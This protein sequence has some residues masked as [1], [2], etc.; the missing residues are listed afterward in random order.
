MSQGMTERIA[1][2]DEVAALPR[3]VCAFM[4]AEASSDLCLGLTWFELLRRHSPAEGYAPRIYV[5]RAAEGEAIDCV[6]FAQRPVTSSAFGA[7]RLLSLTNFYTMSFAPVLR[8][9]LAD[10]REP[11]RCLAAHILSERPGWDVLDFR[12]LIADAASTR[13]LE[14]ALGSVGMVLDSYAQFDNWYLPCAGVSG[15]QYMASRPSQLRNTVTRKAKKL[16]KAHRFEIAICCTPQ[17]LAKALPDYQA[18]YA[19][20]WKEPESYPDFVPALMEHAA[21]EGRLRLGLLYV[22]GMPAAAQIWLLTGKKALIYKLAYDEAYAAF[23]VGS[24]LTKAMFEHVL[25]LDKVDEIDYGVG[26]EPYKLDWMSE[27][28]RVIGLLAFNPRRLKG[29][30]AA[31]RHFAGRLWRGW[32]T[33]WR[34]RGS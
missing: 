8:R 9:E 4:E 34:S 23:S 12:S 15:A 31:G 33:T 28:R 19:R 24:I 13:A 2:F 7:R 1:V 6:L 18:V 25:D 5:V 11:L 27:K 29:L 30:S 32:R 21:G 3:S 17:E 14:D 26:S 20:S 22:D 16:A 10:A